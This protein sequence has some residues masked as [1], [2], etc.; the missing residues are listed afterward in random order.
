MDNAAECVSRRECE[1]HRRDMTQKV[2]SSS[3]NA[4]LRM[5]VELSDLMTTGFDK[6]ENNL[7]RRVSEKMEQSNVR[8]DETDKRLILI[9]DEIRQF[10]EMAKEDAEQAKIQAQKTD[11]LIA[12]MSF[13]K[14][15]SP[16]L[17]VLLLV[18]LALVV[19][20]R[21]FDA[22]ALWELICR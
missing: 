16:Y 9:S 8:H 13:V 5:K 20:G 12:F 18:I 14:K 2:D 11:E 22:E 7:G 3:E 6:I 4:F 10:T 15:Y 19:T 21:I 17:V 1:Q